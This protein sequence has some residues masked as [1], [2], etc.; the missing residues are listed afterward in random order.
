MVNRVSKA[1]AARDNKGSKVSKVS[2]GQQQGGGS[3]GSPMGSGSNWNAGA[4]GAGNLLGP[5]GRMNPQSSDYQG[6]YQQTVQTLQQLQQQ[7]KGDPSMQK[8]VAGLLQ[9]LRQ[10]RPV[11]LFQRSAPRAA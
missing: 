5:N 3:Q 8:D 10:V 6:Q 7:L 11:R 1:S 9:Q 2:P 4:N